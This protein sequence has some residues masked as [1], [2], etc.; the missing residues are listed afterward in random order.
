MNVE[1][2]VWLVVVVLA[3]AYGTGRLAFRSRSGVTADVCNLQSTSTSARG[4]GSID[5]AFAVAESLAYSAASE[6]R[7]SRAPESALLCFL[8][9]QADRVLRVLRW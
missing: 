2:R 3:L 6:T 8:T 7:P 9:R 5:T 4:R 1:L